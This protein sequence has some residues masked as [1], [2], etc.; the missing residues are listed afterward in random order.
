MHLDVL[1][2]NFGKICKLNTKNLSKI[3]QRIGNFN[4]AWINLGTKW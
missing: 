2:F 3:G 4:V 1:K